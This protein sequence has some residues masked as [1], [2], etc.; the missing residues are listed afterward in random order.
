VGRDEWL[1]NQDAQWNI[2]DYSLTV[3][4]RR[5]QARAREKKYAANKGQDKPTVGDGNGG[6]VWVRA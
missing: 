3:Q 4:M 6:V 1:I 5:E 2:R